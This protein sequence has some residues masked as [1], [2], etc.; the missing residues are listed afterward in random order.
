MKGFE[1]NERYCDSII[2]HYNQ[3]EK[4][5]KF[6]WDL[7]KSLA[8]HTGLW[9]ENTKNLRE[10]LKN[11]NKLVAKMA[12]IKKSD[13][14]LDAGCGVGGTSIF[15]AKEYG[16]RIVG[17]NLSESQV[18]SALKN[19]EI[20]NFDNK[21]KFLQMN[22]MKTNFKSKTFDVVI[23]V[24]SSCYAP[25]KKKLFKEIFRIIKPKG[26]LVILDGFFSKSSYTPNETKLLQKGMNGWAVK[27]FDTVENYTKF[28]NDSGFINVRYENLTDKIMESLRKAFIFSIPAFV[29]NKVGQYFNM[30]TKVE[31][32]IFRAAILQYIAVKRNLVECGIFCAQ[33]K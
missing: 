2:S 24:E 12:K 4:Y 15:L 29:F 28:A 9:H 18:E 17:I 5:Y 27:S 7:N 30:T 23:F 19:A 6:F 21:I 11:E 10:A 32:D 13:Y 20:H 33:K 3:V 8:F 31:V 25:D 14:I 26:R 16:C 1:D 22:Y